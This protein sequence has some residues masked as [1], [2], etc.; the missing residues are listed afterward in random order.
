MPGF[1]LALAPNEALVEPGFLRRVLRFSIPA[2][3][4]AGATTYALY[5]HVRRIDDIGLAEARNCRTSG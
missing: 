2:G 3:L 4:V 5:E 1:F